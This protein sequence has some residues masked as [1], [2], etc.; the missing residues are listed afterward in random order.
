M[1]NCSGN[2]FFG[3]HSPVL[4]AAEANESAD[5]FASISNLSELEVRYDADEKIVWQFMKPAGCPSFTPGLI[6]D[7]SAVIDA[8][9]QAHRI[10]PRPPVDYLVLGSALPGIYNLGGDLARFQRLILAGDREALRHYAHSCIE[11]QYRRAVRMHLP[12]CTIALVQGDALGGGFEVA[13]SH[14]VIIAEKRAKFGLP[15]ILF[16]LF[17]GMGAYSFLSRR[18]D[19]A[20]A[21]RMMTS[22]RLYS[23]DEL[24]EMGVVDLV[25]EDGAGEEAVYDFIQGHRRASKARL[26]VAKLP[27]MVTP[28]T[29]QE[30]IDITDLW[31]ETALTLEARDLRKMQH[32]VAAQARRSSSNGAEEQ[33]RER[34][35]A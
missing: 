11:A 17:P 22:G 28:V 16:N 19:S 5:W 24:Y 27:D 3:S 7:C 2:P 10:S 1:S 26:A 14:D 23:A 6:Q 31:V 21:Q 9:E 20:R 15:E 30:L 35:S 34:A 29:R 12:L 4:A 13:L 33:P 8:V 18:L 25:A 32:L